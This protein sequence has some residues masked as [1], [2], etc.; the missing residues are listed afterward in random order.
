MCIKVRIAH[1]L[2]QLK[3]NFQKGKVNLNLVSKKLFFFFF[4]SFFLSFFFF[5]FLFVCLFVW[6]CLVLFGFFCNTVYREV[7][8]TPV[9]LKTEPTHICL[10][11]GTIIK[12]WI[13]SLHTFHNKYK[14]STFAVKMTS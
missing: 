3:Y 9:N 14:H 8:S 4:F 5:F 7:F 6:F 12:I 1:Y 10:I 13:F 11:I 2:Y